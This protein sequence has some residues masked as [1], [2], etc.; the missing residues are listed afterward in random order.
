MNQN[1][2]TYTVVVTTDNSNRKLLPYLTATLSFQIDHRQD[3]L[4]VPNSALRWKPKP[5]QVAPD[6]RQTVAASLT[7]SKGGGQGLRRGNPP[8]PDHNPRNPPLRHRQRKRRRIK[9][10]T[11]C[12]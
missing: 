5:T 11:V 7:V 8:R 10:T 9:N 1:V 2:V 12:G 3:V 4:L 6:V